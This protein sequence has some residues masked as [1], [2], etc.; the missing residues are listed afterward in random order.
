MT[1]NLFDPVVAAV[2]EQVASL[3]RPVLG[4]RGEVR[5]RLLSVS[6]AAEYLGRTPKAIHAMVERGK[7]PVV[8]VDSR[9]FFDVTDLDRWIE[10]HKG[11]AR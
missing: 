8:R 1:K 10:K 3:L 6:E 2:A 5:K 11:H 7:I 4:C 9:R